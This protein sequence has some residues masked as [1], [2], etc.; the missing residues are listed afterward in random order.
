MFKAWAIYMMMFIGLIVHL[1]DT[2]HNLAESD[3]EHL[4]HKTKGF[5]GSDISVC[6]KDVLFEPVR[7]T[8]DAMFFFRNPEDMWIPCGPK[9]QSAVQTTIQDLAAKGLA[10]KILP[11]PISRTDFDKVLARQRPT[12]S[13]SD[14]DVHERFTKEFGEEG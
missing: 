4:A 10:S 13:K 9:Q 11:P 1:G 7:K 12:V 8:Q 2:P 14:L 3:F 6:V 5:S